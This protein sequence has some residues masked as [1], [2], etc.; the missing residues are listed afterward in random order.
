MG[1][2]KWQHDPAASIATRLDAAEALVMTE[3]AAALSFDAAAKAAGIT[4]GGVQYAF[5]TRT[6][7]IG[8]TI[9]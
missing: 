2:M 6:N 5:G 4:K 9:A 8:S 1:G 3:G 7:L